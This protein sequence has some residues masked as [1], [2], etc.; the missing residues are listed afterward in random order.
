MS[1]PASIKRADAVRIGVFD[2]VVSGGGVRFFTLKL[3]EEFSRLS[4]GGWHFHLM[5]PLFDSSDKFLAAPRLGHVSFERISLGARARARNVALPALR[6][7]A[8]QSARWALYEEGVCGDE[9]RSLRAGDGRGLRWLDERADEFDLIYLPYP[10]LTLPGA[11]EWRPKKPLVI[12]LHDLAHEQ[13]DAWGDLTEPLRREVPRWTQL[14]DLVIFSSDYVKREAQKLYGLPEERARRIHLAPAKLENSD[15]P[16]ARARHGLTGKYVFTLGWAAKH[17]RVDTIVEGFA[18]FKRRTGADVAL[19]VAGPRT[20]TLAAGDTHGLEVGRDLFALGYVAD[21]DIPALYR[22]AEAVVTASVSEAGLN[23]MI[24]D[25][26][27]YGRPVICS[28]I[29][30]FVERLGTDD[31]L[32]LTFD[33]HSPQSLAAAFARLFAEPARA[34]SRARAAKKFID[35]RTLSDV[36]RDYLAA[37][38]SVLAKSAPGE[39]A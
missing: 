9:Q 16:E 30:Q 39:P 2:Q 31:A 37:F 25:A 22:D 8:G 15:G 7:V 18:L 14:A 19:V 26:M 12:T 6:K 3:L 24:F 36:G 33:P 11:G 28:N 20:E 35:S 27:S 21:E 38:K 32:A 4:S 29:P 5:W 13:T 34:E 23:A 10:Y 17:K 1:A